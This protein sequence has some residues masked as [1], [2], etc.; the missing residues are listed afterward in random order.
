MQLVFL[1]F[2]LRL[3]AAVGDRRH[4]V[5]I[6]ARLAGAA[7]ATE[8]EMIP[9][10]Y[11]RIGN[12]TDIQRNRSESPRIIRIFRNNPESGSCRLVP[13]RAGS[14]TR[15][16][17]GRGVPGIAFNGNS[18]EFG[19]ACRASCVRLD[20]PAICRRDYMNDQTIRA[21]R[22]CVASADAARERCRCFPSPHTPKF[23]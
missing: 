3:L 5:D 11:F 15:R 7:Q 8:N 20:A 14:G 22:F 10:A 18:I 13:A 12:E 16:H 9:A 1:L 6:S 2:Q 21:S 19:A 23:F 17:A 4:C